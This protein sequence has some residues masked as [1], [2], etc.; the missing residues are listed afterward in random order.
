MYCIV[1]IFLYIFALTYCRYKQVLKNINMIPPTILYVMTFSAML[2]PAGNI[3][4]LPVS[5]EK[6]QKNNTSVTIEIMHWQTPKNDSLPVPFEN[7][8]KKKP[9]LL[10]QDLHPDSV[11]EETLELES[12]MI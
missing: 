4:E 11:K 6:E 12:W 1:L 10:I 9:T 7:E 8:T 5:S 3:N 2:L